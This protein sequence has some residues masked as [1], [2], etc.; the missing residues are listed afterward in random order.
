MI[1]NRIKLATLPSSKRK[2]GFTL[3]ELLIVIAIVIIMAGVSVP[4]MNDFITSQRLQSVA[5]QMVQDLRT[6]REDAILY[7]QDLRVYFC[8]NPASSRTFYLYETYQKNPLATVEESKHYNPGDTPDGKHFIKRDLGYK[9]QFTDK[10]A[11]QN[12][13]N[14]HGTV[15]SKVYYYLTFYCGSGGH[16][17][18][19]PS[20]T[21]TS[22]IE[23][24]DPN[25][26]KVIYVII[27][28]V[29]KVQMTFTPP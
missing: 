1:S 15:N 18:G 21:T 19:Q 29:G 12:P 4:Y 17:R 22:A 24:T 7:Q 26:H 13:F 9:M 20:V 8:V 23:I 3:I 10:F 11:T 14:L 28:S 6:V 27:D 25:T 5:W 16:F 2:E